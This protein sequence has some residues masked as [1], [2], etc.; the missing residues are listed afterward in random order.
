MSW[1]I[2]DLPTHKS[3]YKKFV[4]SAV[5]MLREEVDRIIPSYRDQNFVVGTMG[6]SLGATLAQ[7]AAYIS[8]GFIQ[9]HL[10]VNPYYALDI[11][12]S[13]GLQKQWLD[14]RNETQPE[15]CLREWFHDMLSKEKR[16]KPAAQRLEDLFVEARPLPRNQTETKT[17]NPFM[18][19]KRWFVKKR[20]AKLANQ[21]THRFYESL[22]IVRKVLVRLHNNVANRVIT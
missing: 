9:R 5:E 18:K 6:L 15:E 22:N 12:A 11:P 21:F 14:C 10:S 16:P 8:N 17:R 13:F 3:Q 2:K 4:K 19:M 1:P 7:Y 20:D